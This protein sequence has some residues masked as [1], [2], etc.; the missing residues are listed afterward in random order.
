MLVGSGYNNMSCKNLY[1]PLTPTSLSSLSLGTLGYKLSRLHFDQFMLGQY[2]PPDIPV[3]LFSSQNL[4]I[5]YIYLK[6]KR[7]IA[8]EVIILLQAQA[9]VE[10][11][12][13]S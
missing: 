11:D 4:M 9:T 1:L 3:L 8:I 5:L 2:S 6:R 12:Q 10:I 7:G 13:T